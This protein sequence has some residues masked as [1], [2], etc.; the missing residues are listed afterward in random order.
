MALPEGHRVEPELL[1]PPGGRDVHPGEDAGDLRE[2][3]RKQPVAAVPQPVRQPVS[4][5]R[6]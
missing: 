5:D 3:P 1:S 6:V 2:Q 4:P